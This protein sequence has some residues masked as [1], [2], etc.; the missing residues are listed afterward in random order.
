MNDRKLAAACGLYCGPCEYHGNKCNGCGHEKGKPFWTTLAKVEICP[1]Y[2]CCVNKKE[3]E[4]CGLC[5]E[6]PCAMFKEFTDP[7]LSPEEARKSVLSRQ[8]ELMKRREIGTER[9]LEGKKR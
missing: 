6:L 7:S 9:W 4:H 1:L 2:D 3:L 5:G 8:S